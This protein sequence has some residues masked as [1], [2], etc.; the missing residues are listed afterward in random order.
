MIDFNCKTHGKLAQEDI[1]TRGPYPRCWICKRKQASDSKRKR[2]EM[3]LISSDLG[4]LLFEQP[5]EKPVNNVPHS[6]CQ[7]CGYTEDVVVNHKGYRC[8]P[9][10]LEYLKKWRNENKERVAL[11]H[12]EYFQRN[13]EKLREKHRINQSKYRTSEKGRSKR[14]LWEKN[15]SR[16]SNEGRRLSKRNYCLS[17]SDKLAEKAKAIAARQRATLH[18]R[19]IKQLILSMPNNKLR[20]SDIP[21]DLVDAYRQLYLLRKLILEKKHGNNRA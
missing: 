12:K 6:Y 2:K 7:K 17:N 20:Y 15:N 4:K 3:K 1:Y 18:D 9:C 5:P 14:R 16:A 21:E 11:N 13:K 8:R 19:Y 10:Q